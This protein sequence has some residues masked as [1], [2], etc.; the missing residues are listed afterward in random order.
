MNSTMWNSTG[1]SSLTIS[2][3]THPGSIGSNITVIGSHVLES[4]TPSGTKFSMQYGKKQIHP[5]LYFKFVKS[6]IKEVQLP[7]VEQR[8]RN[9]QKLLKNFEEMGQDA[10]F[11]M[12]M[13][14]LFKLTKHAEAIGS[15]YTKVIE[16]KDID[17]FLNHANFEKKVIKYAD[18][19]N[20]PRPVPKKN[21]S[22][23]LAAKKTGIFDNFKILYLDYTDENLKTTKQKIIEKD[24]IVFGVYKEDTSKHF[25]ITDWIDKICDLTLNQFLDKM[26]EEDPEYDLTSSVDVDLDFINRI[27]EEYQTKVKRLEDT[28]RSNFKDLA[29]DEEIDKLKKERDQYATRVYN[30]E[31]E[32]STISVVKKSFWSKL[33]NR[34]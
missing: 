12:L 34:R 5:R 27:K 10:P 8:L 32:K 30:L 3:T 1:T 17:K 29:K 14:E 13:G 25:F 22:L 26:K 6:K 20:F 31:A 23:I 28:K 11:E 16:Q 15:G 4:V 18:F 7:H 9:I 2:G 21:K 19:A 33:F 24:P